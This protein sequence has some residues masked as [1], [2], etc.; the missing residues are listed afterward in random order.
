M[1][2]M[3]RCSWTRCRPVTCIAADHGTKVAL[4]LENMLSNEGKKQRFLMI[5]VLDTVENHG[6]YV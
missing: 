2:G 4:G 5:F 1:T 3:T 6:G